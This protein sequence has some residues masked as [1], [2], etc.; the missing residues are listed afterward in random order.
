MCQR[1]NPTKVLVVGTEIPVDRD[2]PITYMDGFSQ[3]RKKRM[4]AV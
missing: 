1:L 4:E 2:A 3:Q